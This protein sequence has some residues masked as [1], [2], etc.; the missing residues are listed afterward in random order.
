MYDL[1][2]LPPDLYPELQAAWPE[3]L[4]SEFTPAP[5]ALLPELPAL[6]RGFRRGDRL[7]FY[8]VPAR[9][10]SSGH[11]SAGILRGGYVFGWNEEHGKVMPIRPQEWDLELPLAEFAPRHFPVISATASG[12][13]AGWEQSVLLD[14]EFARYMDA[15]TLQHW[16]PGRMYLHHR[17]PYLLGAGL[18]ALMLLVCFRYGMVTKDAPERTLT[19]LLL[20]PLG[21]LLYLQIR[22]YRRHTPV[23]RALADGVPYDFSRY[24]DLK[25]SIT[26]WE[27]DVL[28]RLWR[29]RW[30]PHALRLD[31]TSTLASAEQVQQT[32]LQE[33]LAD[34]EGYE[35]DGAEERAL[36]ERHRARLREAVERRESPD[37][38]GLKETIAYQ[39]AYLRE[40]GD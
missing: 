7:V 12:L 2:E 11:F 35:P 34:L 3:I 25:G 23:F 20:L 38:P 15:L 24:S 30:Q 28:N 5:D 26:A 36:L 31:G 37:A 4:E 6:Q 29:S 39:Q 19:L 33:M 40:I 22:S 14:T 27:R 18:A 13:Q 16:S 10:E 21:A 32:T 8:R 1:T 17:W 9:G